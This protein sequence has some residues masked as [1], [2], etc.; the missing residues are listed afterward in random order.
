VAGQNKTKTL[1]RI[2]RKPRG[3]LDRA[4][5]LRAPGPE[6]DAQGSVIAVYSVKGGVGKSTLAANLAWCAAQAGRRTLLWDLDAA[7][8]AGFL[9]G[10]EPEAHGDA[11]ADLFARLRSPKRLIRETAFER[12]DL[13]PAD[14]S[15]RALDAQLLRLGKRRRV[16]KLA[17]EL[18]EQYDVIILDCPPVLNELSAQVMR[19]ADAVIVPLPPSP[20]SA[21]ALDLVKQEIATHGV[22]RPPMLPVLSML[23]LRRALHR[24]V[25]E[26]NPGWPAVP[27]ASVVEQGAVRRLPVGAFA[28]SS[29]AAQAFERLWQA[30]AARLESRAA[31]R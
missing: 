11:A 25:R 6:S 23:D 29:P 27:Y 14:E 21:R 24:E 30:I 10:A 9:L 8:G 12:L 31:N 13:L 20:L 1:P 17:A 2:A 7:G 16:A 5:P 15:I 3:P 26:G 22:Q 19:A 4:G 28:P 18:A